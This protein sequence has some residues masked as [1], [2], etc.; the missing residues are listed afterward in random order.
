MGSHLSILVALAICLTLLRTSL[1]D[2]L[3]PP[4]AWTAVAV[5]LYLV[6]AAGLARAAAQAGVRAAAGQDARPLR[7]HQRLAQL[8]PVFLLGGLAG[9]LWSGYGQWISRTA[10]LGRIPLAEEAAAMA[11]FLVAMVLGWVAAYPPFRLMKLATIRRQAQAGWPAR[12]PWTLGEYLGYNIRHQLL[13][14]L[15]PVGLILLVADA[16]ELYALPHLKADWAQQALPVATAAWAGLVFLLAPLMVAR[17][18]RTARLEEGPLRSELEQFCR[19]LKVGARDILVWQT[20]GMIANAAVMGLLARLRYVLISDLLLEQ[21][22]RRQVEAVFAHEATHIAQHHIFYSL[23]FAACSAV[24]TSAAAGLAGQ[25]LH[26][27]EDAVQIMALGLLAVAWALVYGW[28]SRRFERQSDVWAAWAATSDPRAVAERTITPEGAAVFAMSLQRIAQLS[29]L[30][31][32]QRNW[33]HG[34]IAWRVQHVLMLGAARAP[35]A[36]ID[37]LVRRIKLALWAATALSAAL[38]LF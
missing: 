2:Q 24:L 17:I 9:V 25:W 37:R 34:P 31:M 29:G 28:I 3:A 14:V 38:V 8:G 4:S 27:G 11:P 15:V 20:G 6:V 35:R 32:H 1:A 7:R 21:L 22:D 36:G 5:A 23:L 26:L 30:P 19:R 10:G 13:F 33:R 16:L 18:W 12:P